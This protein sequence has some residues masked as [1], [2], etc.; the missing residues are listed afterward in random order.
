MELT[1]VRIDRAALKETSL[2][3]SKKIIEVEQ[4]VFKAAG[5]EFNVNSP[6]NVG[7]VL[8]DRLKLDE[9][10][11]K[12]KTGQYSTSEEV[13]EKIA[14][15]HPVINLILEYRG[16]KKLLTTYVDSLPELIEK[17]TDKIHTS[18][19]QAVAATGRLS[20]SNPNLQNIPIRTDVGRELRRAFIPD[21]GCTFFSA[22][23]SQIELRLIAELSGDP[24]M[25]DAFNSGADIH[26]ATAAKIYKVDIT[27]VTREMRAKA[28]TANF[29]IIYGISAFGLA[30]RLNISR[31]EAKQLIDG[32]FESFPY[33][34]E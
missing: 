33:V 31:T 28:K 8:F 26:S 10:A 13:L 22:D 3:L 19:N 15:R 20:S 29:G 11:K 25:I 34:R 4:D 23:Y 18:Y 1:G 9:K 14:D 12:T 30:N 6:K 7:E 21:E 27:E 16:L 5:M 24:N 32:Y 17:T 2:L